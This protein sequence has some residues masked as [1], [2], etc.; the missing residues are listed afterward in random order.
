MA[1]KGVS[2]MTGAYPGYGRR[3]LIGSDV[4]DGPDPLKF[5]GVMVN[6]Y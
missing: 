3:V 1:A 4:V 5:I 2:E 6:V